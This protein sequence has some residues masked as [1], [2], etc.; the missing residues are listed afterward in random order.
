MADLVLANLEK[1]TLAANSIGRS[2][3]ARG[4]VHTW[5]LSLAVKSASD[6][7]PKAKCR[8]RNIVRVDGVRD[9]F[10]RRR[11]LCWLVCLIA[12]AENGMHVVRARMTSFPRVRL[13]IVHRQA[14]VTT[15]I[16]QDIWPGK[17]YPVLGPLVRHGLFVSVFRIYLADNSFFLQDQKWWAM[18]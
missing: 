9:L 10:G 15:V 2:S 5:K 18:W 7:I 13:L 8:G 14:T 11:R 3:A 1:V 12:T 17:I 6:R 4:S 16:R